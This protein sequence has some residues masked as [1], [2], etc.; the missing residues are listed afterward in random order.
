VLNLAVLFTYHTLL[1]DAGGFD[2]YALAAAVIA[3]IGMMQYKWGMI[4][5]IIGS[6][7]AGFI[8]KTML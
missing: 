2:W 5:V 3:F 7:L 6:A 4:P 8:W 1:P